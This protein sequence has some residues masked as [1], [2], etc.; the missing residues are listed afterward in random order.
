MLGVPGHGHPVLAG[1]LPE[2]LHPALQGRLPFGVGSVLRQPGFGNAADHGDLLAVDRELGQ[3]L[4]EVVGKAAG[5]PAAQL[6]S[7]LI[8]N[9]VMTITRPEHEHKGW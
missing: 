3:F 8:R 1:A 2:L 6:L 5:E 9:H 4:E 7:L